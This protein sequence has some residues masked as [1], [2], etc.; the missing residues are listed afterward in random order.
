MFGVGL[1]EVQP[2]TPFRRAPV[3]RRAQ[4][5]KIWIDGHGGPG[6]VRVAPGQPSFPTAHLKHTRARETADLMQEPCLIPVGIALE[7][8]LPLLHCHCAKPSASYPQTRGQR[9]AFTVNTKGKCSDLARRWMA[10][11]AMTCSNKG[12]SSVTLKANRPRVLS[13]CVHVAPSHSI[14]SCAGPVRIPDPHGRA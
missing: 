9:G 4:A 14:H 10:G 13:A 6:C 8:H 3:A 5:L 2:L 1:H 11:H 7:R 12:C